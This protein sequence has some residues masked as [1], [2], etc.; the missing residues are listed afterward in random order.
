MEG[1]DLEDDWAFSQFMDTYNP[2]LG[3][4]MQEMLNKM[5]IDFDSWNWWNWFPDNYYS[6]VTNMMTRWEY[7]FH[8]EN[9]FENEEN[10]MELWLRLIWEGQDQE[11]ILWLEVEVQ[12]NP[13]SSEGWQLMGQIY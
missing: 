13:E 2:W 12:R 10:P 5:N 9:K 1:L 3:G 7:N 4:T 11:A 8:K 6:P